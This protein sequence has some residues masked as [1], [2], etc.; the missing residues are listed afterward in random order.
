MAAN[1]SDKSMVKKSLSLKNMLCNC[2]L[3]IIRIDLE[4][5]GVEVLDSKLGQVTIQYDSSK[6]PFKHIINAII[7]IK[8]CF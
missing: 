1:N 6:I 3:R 5:I 4:A 7:E 2:C 8:N